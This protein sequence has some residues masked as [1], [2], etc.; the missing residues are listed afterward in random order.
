MDADRPQMPTDHRPVNRPGRILLVLCLTLG[1]SSLLGGHWVAREVLLWD[2]ISTI[3]NLRDKGGQYVVNDFQTTGYDPVDTVAAVFGD[4]SNDSLSES[5]QDRRYISQMLAGALSDTPIRAFGASFPGNALDWMS[6]HLRFLTARY[7]DIDF[8]VIPLNIRWISPGWRGRDQTTGPRK[9]YEIYA[10]GLLPWLRKIDLGYQS[11]ARE[12]DP[13]TDL[14]DT[15]VGPIDGSRAQLGTDD[16]IAK[17]GGE[18]SAVQRLINGLRISLSYGFELKGND[19]FFILFDQIAATCEKEALICLF[20]L[21]PYNL[22][23]IEMTSDARVTEAIHETL[24]RVRHY[25]RERE[26]GLL[27][28]SR[29][30]APA[31]FH[32]VVNEHVNEDGRR[33]I[34]YC[35]GKAL[36]A[37]D[38]TPQLR[39]K[40]LA[41]GTEIGGRPGIEL[42]LELDGP[43]S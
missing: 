1:A 20:Y 36:I 7:P 17:F 22:K 2:Q 26:Y 41:C 29:D 28:L 13:R 43:S 23:H 38:A 25:A 18:K 12:F 31:N 6:S 34:A 9:T 8:A 5:D 40:P 21:P 35:L 24:R 42:D 27:D 4:S 37:L 16:Y 3:E 15:V 14:F 11:P 33:F 30:L 19:P 10:A 32:D 39:R